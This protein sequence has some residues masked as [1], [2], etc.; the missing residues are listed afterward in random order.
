M[1]LKKITGLFIGLCGGLLLASCTKSP[2]M[3]IEEIEKIQKSVDYDLIKKSISKPYNNQKFKA[4]RTGG[5]WHDTILSDPKTFNQLV[6]IYDGSSYAIISKTLD[7]LFEYNSV[8][9]EWKGRL[10][11]YEIETD[12]NAGTLTLHCSLRNDVF[13]TYMGKEEKI[14]LTSD[15]FLFWYN[16]IEGDEE[17]GLG[18]YEGQC[19][20][21]PDGSRQHIDCI[22]IDDKNF[23]F[24]F[25]RIIAEPLL[26][27][28]MSP[29][30]SFL[31]KPAKDKGGITG[32]KSLFS[33]DCDLKSIPSCGEFYISEYVPS[34]RLVFARNPY[35]WEK[36]ENGVSSPYYEE[37]SCQIVGD[38]NTEYLLF[39]QGKTET[40]APR[41]EE[42]SDVVNN[43][44]D[45]YTVFNAEGSMSSY[46]WTFNQN[47][48][49]KDEAYYKWFCKKEFRQ[50]MSCILNRERII[51]QTYRGLAEPHYFFFPPVNPYYNEKIQLE[52]RYDPD[53]ALK[54]LKGAGFVRD[55]DGILRDEDGNAIEFD[56][57]LASGITVLSDMAQIVCDEASKIGIKINVRQTDFQKLVESLTARYDWQSCFI[58]LGS[59]R[60]PN[61]GS[62]VWRS[63]G[64]LH[65]WYPMQESPATDWEAR[66]D[67]LHEQGTYTL[68]FDQAKKIWDEY[69]SIILEQCPVIYLVRSRS[70]FAIR[71]RWDL[72]N[73]YYDNRN[74]LESSWIYLR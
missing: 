72:S 7:S 28:N 31:L 22:K 5:V 3:T 26:A 14:P 10:A 38:Q 30:P 21:M 23:D 37:L 53:R 44:K 54:L 49:N 50:A 11:S 18:G 32:I 62:N 33:V 24:I 58:A 51:N 45:D 9:R 4:G 6:G 27:V 73:V 35:F 41:P 20:N 59:L 56:L 43:Q 68:D 52:Y 34:R 1:N 17:A 39:R 61:Q 57:A 66:I 15:D 67:F 2:D 69:Q 19:V 70:F 36:D 55:G 65:M 60:F 74:G 25:P 71:N 64:N 29:C 48:K 8:S 16:E 46:M 47:P 63:D 12:K 13:W 40:Y 42:L